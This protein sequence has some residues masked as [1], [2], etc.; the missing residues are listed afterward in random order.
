[1]DQD[2]RRARSGAR[3]LASLRNATLTL[4]RRAGPPIREARKNLREDR[5]HAIEVVTGRIL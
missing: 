5:P 2:C 1:M 4:I 3:P